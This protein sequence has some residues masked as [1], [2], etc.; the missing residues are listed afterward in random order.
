LTTLNNIPKASEEPLAQLENGF[1]KSWMGT[2]QEVELPVS[3]AS[4]RKS[5]VPELI[6]QR[7]MWVDDYFHYEDWR[8]K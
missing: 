4:I 7:F 5:I 6:N 2:R 8:A 1:D 3:A